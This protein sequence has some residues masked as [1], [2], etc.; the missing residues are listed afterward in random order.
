MQLFYQFSFAKKLQTQSIGTEK[1]L[2]TLLNEKG[3]HKMLV[4]LTPL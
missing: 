4:K 1:F 3:A 2:K